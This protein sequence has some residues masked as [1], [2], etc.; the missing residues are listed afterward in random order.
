M[1]DSE[2]LTMMLV[3]SL[4][5]SFSVLGVFIWGSKGGQFD[6]TKRMMDGLLFDSQDDLNEAIKREDKL[7]NAKNGAKKKEAQ[8]EL[9]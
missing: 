2:I 7:K 1:V 6:D 5:V 4:I 9:P 3:V 8:S